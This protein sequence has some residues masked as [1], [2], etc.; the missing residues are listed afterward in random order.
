MG[1]RYVL[2]KDEEWFQ[3]TQDGH[4]MACCDCGF[5]H[6]IS[7]RVVDGIVQLKVKRLNRSTAMRRR[8]KKVNATSTAT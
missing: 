4:R 7:F 3:P 8:Y 2:I 6:E 5:V 1:V